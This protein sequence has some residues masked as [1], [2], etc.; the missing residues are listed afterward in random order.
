MCQGV[1]FPCQSLGWP[2]TH[3]VAQAGLE[4]G[5]PLSQPPS[6][7]IKDMHH[8]HEFKAFFLTPLWSPA[9]F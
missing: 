5:I 8:Y 6:T 1:Y 2:P 7:G 4:L 3:Y 9:V